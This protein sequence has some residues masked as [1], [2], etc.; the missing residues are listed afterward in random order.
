[1]T[2]LHLVDPEL[3]KVLDALPNHDFGN[4]DLERFRGPPATAAS[5][6]AA[7]DEREISVTEVLAA[8]GGRSVGVRLY[9]PR[10]PQHPMPALLD[11]HG[12][13]FISGSV[14]RN[15]LQNRR[16]AKETGCLVA[17]VRYSLSP[18]TRFP[19]A[20]EE[21]YAALEWLDAHCGELGLARGHTV[22]MG[23][24]AGGGLAAALALLARD[25]GALTIASQLLLWPMLDDRTCIAPHPNPHA[26]EFVWTAEANRFGWRSLLG[27]EPGSED[28]S[29]YAAPARA[30]SLSGLP[31]TMMIATTLDLFVD[32][33]LDYARRLTRSG[34]PV[35][36]HLLPGAFHGFLR[37]APEAG[38][39][40]AAQAVIDAALRRALSPRGRD[41]PSA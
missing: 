28:V 30:E 34:V 31:P 41:T 36:L 2:S 4:L 27:V 7:E 9:R 12:G 32:E 40:R 19:G 23:N 14:E 10:D 8:T 26:G 1:M 11:I 35:E 25:R 39:S 33:N 37:M 16:I 3:R 13:G 15:D 6:G 29:P 24:S 20:I 22:V 17:A 5:S 38:V 21:C 18:E